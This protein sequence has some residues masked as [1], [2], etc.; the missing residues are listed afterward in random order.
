MLFEF[1]TN[2]WFMTI[3]LLWTIPW[4][5]VALWKSARNKQKGWFMVMLVLGSAA[6]LEMIYLGFFQKKSRR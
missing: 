5:G 2:P 1:I 4:K 3:L 6:I